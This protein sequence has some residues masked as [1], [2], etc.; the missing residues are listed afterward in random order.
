M[1]MEEETKPTEIV[2]YTLDGK[3]ISL[4]ELNEA[5]NKPGT[6]LVETAP[7]CFK[8]LQRLNG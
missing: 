8:T 4:V 2:K 6:K 1:L 5:K 7:G 3:E